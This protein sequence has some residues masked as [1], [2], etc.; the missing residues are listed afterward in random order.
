M[1]DKIVVAGQMR[2]GEVPAPVTEAGPK[3]LIKAT[4]ELILAAAAKARGESK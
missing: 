4:A 2:R 1:A 3:T